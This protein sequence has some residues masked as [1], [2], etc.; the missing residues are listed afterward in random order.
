MS[1]ILYAV[2]YSFIPS[3][4]PGLQSTNGQNHRSCDDILRKVEISGHTRLSQYK[5]RAGLHHWT[6]DAAHGVDD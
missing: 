4:I 5:S 1:T 6:S 2:M 3:L